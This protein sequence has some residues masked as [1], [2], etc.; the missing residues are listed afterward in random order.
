M[1]PHTKNEIDTAILELV[2]MGLL[3]KNGE[4]RPDREGRLQP[5]YVTTAL[6]TWLEGT[7]QLESYMAKD[8]LPDRS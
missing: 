4:F 7:G 6:G 1:I 8:F 2:A 5:V 3:E